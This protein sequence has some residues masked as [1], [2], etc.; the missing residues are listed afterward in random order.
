MLRRR[1]LVMLAIVIV[2]VALLAGYKAYSIYQQIQAF[3]APPA[4]VSVSAVVAEQRDWQSQVA[5]IGSLTALRGVDLGVEAGGTVRSV[6]FES[7]QQVGAGQPLLQ[8]DNAVETAS[9]RTAEAELGLA[10]VEYQR[11]SNLIERQAISRSEFDRLGASL[12]KA[13]A[14]VA[15]LKAT[16]AKKRLLAPF[17]GTIGIRQVDVGDYLEPGTPVATLQDLSMLYVDFFLPEQEFARLQ[18]G[19]PLQASVA[20][21]PGERFAG[22][23][24]AINPK[25]EATTRNLQVR[26]LLAN[27]Q[28]RLLPGMFAHLQVLLGERRAQVVVPETAVAYTLYGN[29]LYVVVEREEDGAPALSVERRFVRTGERRDGQ[30]VILEGLQAGE[31]VVSSGQLKLDN[32]TAITLVDDPAAR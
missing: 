14:S 13:R 9:L 26:A 17:A 31:R 8:M 19:Q 23:I 15:Q 10:L 30:V 3:S 25:V 1:L 22:R 32:G 28:G 12:E 5:A 16:L 20:A 7:G 2:V 18:V 4:P 29:S 11:G 24:E 21:W 6:L 27:P